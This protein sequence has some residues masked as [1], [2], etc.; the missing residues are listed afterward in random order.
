M[1][2]ESVRIR[3]EAAGIMAP[4]RE[5]RQ[6]NGAMGRGKVSNRE[7]QGSPLVPIEPIVNQE[8]YTGLQ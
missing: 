6:N 1:R 5:Y 8:N 7:H 3:P 4:G 2:E